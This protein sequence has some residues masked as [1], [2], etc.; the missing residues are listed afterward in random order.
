MS[1][2]EN[3]NRCTLSAVWMRLTVPTLVVRAMNNMLN[4]RFP[5]LIPRG[6][7]LVKLQL[8]SSDKLTPLYILLRGYSSQH[9]DH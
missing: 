2:E 5:F 6:R 4:V 1:T 3:T 8:E 7:P 9:G